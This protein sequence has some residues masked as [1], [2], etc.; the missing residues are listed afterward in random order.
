MATTAR[1]Q[2]PSKFMYFISNPKVRHEKK[3][4]FLTRRLEVKRNSLIKPKQRFFDLAFSQRA[5]D[6]D[7]GGGWVWWWLALFELEYKRL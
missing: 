5:T 2:A 7:G 4:S 1:G 3:H 6:V